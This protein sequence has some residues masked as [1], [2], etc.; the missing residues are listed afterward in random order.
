MGSMRF[1]EESRI[2]LQHLNS[3]MTCLLYPVGKRTGEARACIYLLVSLS[4]YFHL[5]C[6][7]L[8]WLHSQTQEAPRS[9]QHLSYIQRYVYCLW[10][11]KRMS[12]EL[13]QSFKHHDKLYSQKCSQRGSVWGAGISNFSKW[14]FKLLWF[15]WPTGVEELVTML[16]PERGIVSTELQGARLRPNRLPVWLW[17]QGHRPLPLGTGRW[18]GVG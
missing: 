14:I 6:H 10:R 16:L 3:W 11:H 15:I 9:V 4:T 2:S 13:C 5:L 7:P 12:S 17:M 18:W 1:R 8:L